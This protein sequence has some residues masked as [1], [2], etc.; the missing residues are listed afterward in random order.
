MPRPPHSPW[1]HLPNDIWWWVQARNLI[2]NFWSFFGRLGMWTPQS[3]TR[4]I[5]ENS[6]AFCEISPGMQRRSDSPWTRSTQWT[7]RYTDGDPY[8]LR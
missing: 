8:K 4:Y 7:Q 1:S 5:T 6:Y 2:Y 3:T